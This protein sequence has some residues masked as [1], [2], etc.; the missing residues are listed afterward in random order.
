M[1]KILQTYETLC[2]TPSDIVEHLPTLKNLANECEIV[3]ELGTR[4]CYSLFA[5]LASNAKEVYSVDINYNDYIKNTEKMCK[6]E[7]RN[8]KFIL[9]SSIYVDPPKSP[10]LVF[11]DSFHE[12]SHVKQEIAKHS[13][14]ENLKYMAFHDSVAWGRFSENGKPKGVMDA[15]E[16][17]LSNNPNKFKIK[18]HHENCNGLLVLERI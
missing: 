15:I 11:V 8:F 3:L 4:Y 2:R 9:D 18:F 6:E 16:D 10:D 7:N 17:F 5:F 12:F 13:N 1:S 14:Y